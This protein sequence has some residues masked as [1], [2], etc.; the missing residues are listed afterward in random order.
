MQI[1]IL[2]NKFLH[3]CLFI[4]ISTTASA[5]ISSLYNTNRPRSMAQRWEL[6]SV[7]RSGT[8]VI[9]PY[10]PVYIIPARWSSDP[11]EKPVSGNSNPAYNYEEQVDYNN[12]EAKFQISFKV[13]VFESMFWGH[14]DLWVAYTQLNNWQVYN[15]SLSRPFREINYEPEVIVN[16]ATDYDVLGFKGR[17]LGVSFNHRSNGQEMPLSRSW[18]RIIIQAGFEKDNWQVYVKPWLRIRGE[19]KED[20]NPDIEEYM[21]RGELIVIYSKG[22]NSFVFTGRHNLN[23][24]K[25]A[26]GHAEVSWSHIIKGN[27]ST[28]IQAG[29]GYGETMVDYNN[30]QG[31]VGVGVS[32]VGWL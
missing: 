12:L 22:K 24:N 20:D 23:L 8:F 27:L 10:K 4:A 2:L 28:Y 3:C 18:N 26:R 19:K 7:S 13:K 17:M 9:T 5:Q 29:Y 14:G 21:G 25:H 11:N 15:K 6:D 30:L 1:K 32:L 16:F 31:T